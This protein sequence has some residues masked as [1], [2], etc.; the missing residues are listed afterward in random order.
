V[1]TVFSSIVF[2][3][4]VPVQPSF[5]LHDRGFEDSA[6]IGI[7]SAIANIGGP[8]GSFAFQAAS[9]QPIARLLTVSM[10][11]FAVGFFI[12]AKFTGGAITVLGAFVAS[13]GGGV[14]LPLLLAWTVVKLSFEQRGRGSGAFTGSFFLGQFISPIAVLAL[15]AQAGG[16]D[17]TI[18]ILGGICA[19]MA[20][21]SL[22]WSYT[23]P[24][25]AIRLTA[26]TTELLEQSTF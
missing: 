22:A 17:Q 15:S 10:A 26:N 11:L 12:M 4:V 18:W 9:R 19:A 21:T 14:V 23:A 7:A 13:A 5:L 8:A 20:C 3:Y 1:I 25:T 2:F 24:G 16:L 6:S